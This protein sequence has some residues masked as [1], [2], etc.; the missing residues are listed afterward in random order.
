MHCYAIQVSSQYTVLLFATATHLSIL[1]VLQGSLA[2]FVNHSCDPNCYTAIIAVD[3]V[4]KII[5]YAKRSIAA[6]EE[7]SYDYKFPIEERAEDRIA[8]H[9]G[10]AKCR[11]F[12]N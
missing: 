4:K 10:A 1:P 3:S 7:L 12:M 9:C 11:G 2:R 5:I 6:G 8:C